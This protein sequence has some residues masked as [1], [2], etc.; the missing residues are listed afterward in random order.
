MRLSTFCSGNKKRA[1]GKRKG[2]RAKLTVWDQILSVT[3]M[4]IIRTDLLWK[5]VLEWFNA[6]FLSVTNRCQHPVP[7][8]TTS[9][10]EYWN[11]VEGRAV[12]SFSS[13]HFLASL[14][15]LQL[16]FHCYRYK[17]R[18][19][20]N[21]IIYT[22]ARTEGKLLQTHG[23]CET[24]IIPRRKIRCL[25]ESLLDETNYRKNKKSLTNEVRIQ[26]NKNTLSE[27]AFLWQGKQWEMFAGFWLKSWRVFCFCS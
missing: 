25:W 16:H 12:S 5:V 3:A 26:T 11:F 19:E 2:Y 17:A 1:L 27:A 15:E 20:F 14:S 24:T 8:H 4:L 13:P 10:E 21:C 22:A 6:T 9:P 18:T 23:H 7:N